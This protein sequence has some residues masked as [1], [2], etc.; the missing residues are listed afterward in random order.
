MADKFIPLK[1]DFSVAPQITAA[2]VASAAEEGFTLIVNNRPDGEMIGQPTSAEI[3]AAAK[4]AGLAYAHIPVDGRGISPGHISALKSALEESGDKTL[5]YCRSGTRS[6]ILYAYLCAS[7]GRA[8][9]EIISE[10]AMAGYDISGQRPALEA[11]RAETE[12]K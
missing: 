8:A 2:D 9:E 3:E 4:A 5:G 1:A 7:E 10:A 6:T 11:L 12:Q